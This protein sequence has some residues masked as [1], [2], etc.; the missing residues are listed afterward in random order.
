MD[1]DRPQ[2]AVRMPQQAGGGAGAASAAA[3]AK[4]SAAGI[5]QQ[6]VFLSGTASSFGE[7]RGAEEF[8]RGRTTDTETIYFTGGAAG[9]PVMTGNDS[10]FFGP[11]PPGHRRTGSEGQPI[12]QNVLSFE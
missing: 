8:G 7:S 5:S 10:D 12:D 11:V 2:P 6:T 3:A 9:V 1:M 4:A